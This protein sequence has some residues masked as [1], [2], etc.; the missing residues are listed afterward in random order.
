MRAGT[1]MAFEGIL[2]Q[3]F[4]RMPCTF[5]RPLA[6]TPSTTERSLPLSEET[7]LRSTTYRI[8][9]QVGR[10]WLVAPLVVAALCTL[11]NPAAATRFAGSFM[12]DGGGARALGMGSAFVAVADDASAAFWNPAGLLSVPTRQVIAMHSERF[13]DLIDRDYASYVQPLS[14]TGSWSDGAFAFSV[15]HLAVDDIPFTDQLKGD[16]DVNGDGIVDSGEV[17]GL[18]DPVMQ[19]QIQ[20][21]TDRELAFMASYA[22]RLG[23]WQLGGT[24]KF[25]RQSVGQYSSFGVGVDIGALRRDWWRGLDVGIKLQDITSTYLS[26]STG[27]NETIS[28]VVTPGASYDWHFPELGVELTAASALEVHF[29]GRGNTVD[30]FGYQAW[31]GPFEDVSSNLFLGVETTLRDRAHLRFGSHGGFDAT[32][33]TFG[34][35]LELNRFR[36]DYAYAGD[37][38]EIDS[39]THRV[40]LGVDF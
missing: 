30:Q 36:V 27:R 19:D 6:A 13:G 5:A 24:A 18:L 40:S 14:G 9:R 26:W 33:L 38:L 8:D 28:P 3:V 35:G 25:I 10:P 20:F 37:V 32:D 17:L 31:G 11:A 4:E 29:S 34:M 7:H 1:Q 23:S 16:L 22:R 2:M 15:I 21:K 12:A 39:S